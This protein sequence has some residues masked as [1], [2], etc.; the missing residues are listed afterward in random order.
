MMEDT[1]KSIFAARNTKELRFAYKGIIRFIPLF[2]CGGF[3]ALTILFFA[4]GPLDW[5]IENPLKLY[6]FLILCCV[7]LAAGYVLAAFKGR[8]GEKKLNI[9]INTVLI[10]CAAVYLILYV[11]TLIATTG[12]WYPDIVTGIQHTGK[13]YSLT[14]YYAEH[15]SKLVMYARILF[16]PFM[17]MIMPVTLFFMPKL[18]KLGKCLGILVI[19]CALCLS[20]SQGINKLVADT[21][22]QIVLYLTML[23]FTRP[24]KGSA[25][26]YRLGVFLMIIFVCVLFFLYYSNSM[27]NRIEEDIDP[28]EQAQISTEQVDESV[29]RNAMFSFA[30]VREDYFLYWIVPPKYQS[31]ATF[32][33]SYLTHGY[34]GLSIAMEEDFTSTYGMGF[35]DF[36]RRNVFKLIGSEKETYIVERSYM[37]KTGLT[38]W[39]TGDV[40]SSFFVYPASDIS[41][42]GTVIFIF[43]IGYLFS[44]SWKDAL[45]TENPF[46][47]ASFFGFCTMIFYFCANNQMFQSGENFVGFSA[48]IFVWMLSRYI[49]KKRSSV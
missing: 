3:F 42:P 6:S 47:I 28:S 11:P 44:L 17:I 5:G 46:A 41:F 29:I 45:C 12:K 19:V 24:R 32:L 34:N 23:F 7:A 43:V 26:L 31:T 27:K 48:V 30:T 8:T 15:G 37:Y 36:F 25:A 39:K 22:A 10:L 13:A 4:F 49:Q 18:S 21:A 40:W 2:V 14:K 9:N 20:I 1:R 35:S 38:G 33:I 16:S